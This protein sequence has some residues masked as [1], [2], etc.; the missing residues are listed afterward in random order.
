MNAGPHIRLQLLSVT[1][2]CSQTL[3]SRFKASFIGL[4]LAK[5]I[6]PNEDPFVYDLVQ[7]IM[8]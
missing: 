6:L 8:I 2:C 4:S 1:P 5:T 7:L 3:Y